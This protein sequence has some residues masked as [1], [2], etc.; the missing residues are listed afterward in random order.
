MNIKNVIYSLIIIFSI[1]VVSCNN[2]NKNDDGKI[3]AD[4]V[5]NPIS[6][7]NEDNTQGLPIIAFTEYMHDFGRVIQGEIVTYGFKFRNAGKSDLLISGVSTSCGCTASDF[8]KEPLKPGEEGVI[9]ITFDSKGRKG[10][11]RKTATV[12]ANTQPSKRT[13]TIKAMIFV[14]EDS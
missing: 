5:N 9:K 3:P 6:A 2:A 10:F 1:S 8:P 12:L 7:D 13:L 4:V 14:P 11:Q